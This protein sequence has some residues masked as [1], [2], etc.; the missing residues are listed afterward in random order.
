MPDI[1]TKPII[2]AVL[3][4]AG[5]SNRMGDLNKLELQ[6]NG[7]SL[8]QRIIDTLHKTSFQELIV[9]A[10]YQAN[11]IQSLLQDDPVTVI[12]NEHYQQGQMTSVQAGLKAL[13]QPCDGVMICLSDQPLLTVT[14]INKII[15]GFINRNH[16]SIVVPMFKGK[17]GNPI[18][19]DYQHRATI[20]AG[21]RDLGCKRLIEHHPELVSTIEMDNDHTVL[22]MDTPDDYVMFQHLFN[23]RDYKYGKSDPRYFTETT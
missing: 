2:S 16:G 10:G 11:K 19:L 6:I 5:E 7:V 14:D 21:D 20:L 4:A 17:R 8:L 23:T 18:I 1:T 22:D 12:N 9:V 3:L 13:T 15:N